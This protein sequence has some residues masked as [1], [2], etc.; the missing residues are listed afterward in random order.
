M[1]YTSLRKVNSD[2]CRPRG[3]EVTGLVKRLHNSGTR[4]DLDAAKSIT[5]LGLA[6]AKANS[7]LGDAKLKVDKLERALERTK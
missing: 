4:L 1:N 3:V 5:R 6:L 7:K 2:G